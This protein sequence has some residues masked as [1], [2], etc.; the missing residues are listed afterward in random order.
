MSIFRV[1]G[2]N[3]LDSPE[4]LAAVLSKLLDLSMLLICL[5]DSLFK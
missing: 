2:I 3:N 5:I 1:L 4:N